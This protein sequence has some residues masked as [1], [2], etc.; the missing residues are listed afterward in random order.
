MDGALAGGALTHQVL[1]GVKLFSFIGAA[2]CRPIV[3]FGTG[4]GD[5]VGGYG[6]YG[7]WYGHPW[8]SGH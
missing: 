1:T 6:A 7:P 2:E 4:M 5:G 8:Y 3:A